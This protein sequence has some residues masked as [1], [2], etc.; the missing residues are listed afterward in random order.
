MAKFC[1][2][3]GAQLPNEGKFCSE[4]GAAI[5]TKGSSIDVHIER[6]VTGILNVA[7]NIVQANIG[8]LVDCKRCQGSG[9][10]KVAQ[11][12]D[13]CE[14]QGYITS[15]I[16]PSDATKFL[17]ALRKLPL[18]RLYTMKFELKE[19]SAMEDKVALKIIQEKFLSITSCVSCCEHSN[20]IGWGVLPKSMFPIN[21]SETAD[22]FRVFDPLVVEIVPIAIGTGIATTSLCPHCH[23]YGK[24]RL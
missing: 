19:I 24:I 11:P 17:L 1:S 20:L 18:L 7:E 15:S 8:E 2:Q 4:C 13:E 5:S 23:G 10:I 14:R 16:E 3:C 6:D 22:V 12:C 21:T 9:R